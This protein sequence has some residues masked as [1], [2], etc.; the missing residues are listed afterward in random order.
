MGEENS[1]LIIFNKNRYREAFANK[2]YSPLLNFQVDDI[3]KTIEVI[4]SY[5]GNLDGEVIQDEEI[6]AYYQFYLHYKLIIFIR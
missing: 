6:K 1:I 5:G 2:G 3:M 4:K